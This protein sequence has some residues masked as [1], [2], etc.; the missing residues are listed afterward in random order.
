MGIDLT[1]TSHAPGGQSLWRELAPRMALQRVAWFLAFAGTIGW[2]L[3]FSLARPVGVGDE[4]VHLETIE[5]LAR[6]DWALA[7]NLA[8]WP[9]Y[10]WLVYLV[11]LGQ[12]SLLTARLVST[13]SALVALFLFG[14][15]WERYHGAP[16]GVPT[17]LVATLPIL[18]PF[19]AMAYTDITALAA[20]LGAWAA[21]L[22]GHRF[23]AAVLL[24]AA[25]SLRQTNVI[26][27]GFFVC[28]TFL[29]NVIDS[30]NWRLASRR[31]LAET[32]ALLVVLAGFALAVI[33]TGKLLPAAIA[34]NRPRF[35]VAN[36]HVGAQLWMLFTVPL[37]LRQIPSSWRWVRQR[38][39]TNP[40]LVIATA[41][42]VMV[43]IAA[44]GL[45]FENPHPWN[46]HL[47]YWDGFKL[48]FLRNWPLVWM[49]NH[50]VLRWVSAAL[51]VASFFSL[52][53]LLRRQGHRLE[54]FLV[55]L[56][57][58]LLV[59]PHYLVDP[60]YFITVAVFLLFFLRFEERTARALGGWWI[61]LCVVHA[62][63]IAWG[64]S[65][66]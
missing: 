10:H 2:S 59:A 15:T 29:R 20:L 57:G 36:L 19:T 22:S 53:L 6:G 30:A 33:G 50:A 61:L 41:T 38:L 17:L 31:T 34:E 13:L 44:L 58:A 18:Q 14:K 7:G 37:W 62:P 52:G 49:E 25:C 45:T 27:G 66:W 64:R 21:H 4:F 26:W 56:F 11:S 1:H 65:I 51:V 24:V 54:I 28:W 48:H 55:V 5:R 42:A 60:R 63:F 35:N 47:E 32:R 43:A 46:R 3:A 12:P 16:A 40:A 23:L 8:M 39:R 9:A